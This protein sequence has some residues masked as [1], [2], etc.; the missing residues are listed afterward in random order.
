MQVHF[1][2]LLWHKPTAFSAKKQAIRRI[3]FGEYDDIRRMDLIPGL[4][5]GWKGVP[6]RE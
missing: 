5:G 6:G 2:C 4:G 1:Q 3:F